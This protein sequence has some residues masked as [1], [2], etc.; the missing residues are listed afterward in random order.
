MANEETP[1]EYAAISQCIL[2]SSVCV[3]VCVCV[4]VKSCTQDGSV[5]TVGLRAASAFEKLP[6]GSRYQ[7]TA[8]AG[9]ILKSTHQPDTRRVGFVQRVNFLSLISSQLRASRTLEAGGGEG[10]RTLPAA[11]KAVRDQ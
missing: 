5:T 2:I 4:C 6:R 3:C 1:W 7:A 8:R 9:R 10:A 11:S